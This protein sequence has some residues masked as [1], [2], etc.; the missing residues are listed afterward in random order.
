MISQSVAW[1]CMGWE[2]DF[3]CQIGTLPASFFPRSKTKASL[4]LAQELQS[5]WAALQPEGFGFSRDGRCRD[6]N[7]IHRIST[8]LEVFF[9]G[10]PV[11]W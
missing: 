10:I 2:I 7:A 1:G 5:S 8:V 6:W 3:D 11:W 4:L 9:F